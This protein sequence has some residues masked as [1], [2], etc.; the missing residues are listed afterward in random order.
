MTTATETVR[1]VA[2]IPPDLHRWVKARA[3]AQNRTLSNFVETLLTE[4][5]RS[6]DE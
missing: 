1:L 3:S 5:Q 2:Y 4:L 6:E